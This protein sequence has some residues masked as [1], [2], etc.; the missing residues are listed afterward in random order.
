M[1]QKI[2]LGLSMLTITF[3]HGAEQVG[4]GNRYIPLDQ[5]NV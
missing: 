2:L 5:C 3:L 4:P 1:L